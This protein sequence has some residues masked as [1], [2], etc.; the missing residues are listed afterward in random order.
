[1]ASSITR[2][3]GA[4]VPHHIADWAATIPLRETFESLY[5]LVMSQRL[6][7]INGEIHIVSQE[8]LDS[9]YDLTALIDACTDRGIEVQEVID[10]A[11]DLVWES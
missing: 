10:K 4:R 3:I 5:S 9:F 6:S 1:M 7:I 11:V 8:K 2:V